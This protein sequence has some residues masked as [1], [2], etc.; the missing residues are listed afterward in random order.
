MASLASLNIYRAQKERKIVKSIPHRLK[1]GKHSSCY[2][3][4]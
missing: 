4:K 1:K 3:Q 2:R